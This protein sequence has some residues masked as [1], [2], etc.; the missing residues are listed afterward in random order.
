MKNVVCQIFLRDFEKWKSVMDGEAVAQQKA[1]LTLTHLWRSI[2][3]PKCA[4]FVMEA[5]NV[6]RAKAYLTQLCF[7]YAQKRAEVSRYEWHITERM[8]L[9]ELRR[10]CMA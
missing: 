1:G 4:F 8:E 6:E 7:T 9:P 3:N 10:A 5:Q 2:D